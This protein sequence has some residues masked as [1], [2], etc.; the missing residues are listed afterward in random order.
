[1]LFQCLSG[2][3]CLTLFGG[4]SHSLNCDKFREILSLI[5]FSWSRGGTP[6]NS[7]CGC[8]AWFSKSWPYFRPKNVIFHTRFQT[9]P[10]KFI[11][12]FRPGLKLLKLERKQNNSSNVFGI[13]I[14]LCR[15]YS[16]GIK[17]ITTL[18]RSRSSLENHTRFQTKMGKVYTCFQT[19]K[20]Q[21]PYPLERHIL[22]WL[23]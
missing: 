19:K 6:R 10:L 4:S 20:A 11:P 1:M 12:V 8:V 14:F 23:T 5:H 13:R 2:Y 16:S 18:V 21:K 17:T 7:L 22:I 15:S 3:W 9:R